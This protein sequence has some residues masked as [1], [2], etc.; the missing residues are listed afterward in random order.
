MNEILQA[1]QHELVPSIP[2]HQHDSWEL[3]YCTQGSAKFVFDDTELVYH[4]G[5]VVVIPPDTP[6]ILPIADASSCLLLSLANTA[7]TLRTPMLFHDD[8]N[9]SLLHL[10][11]DTAYLFHS[12]SEYRAVLL[13]AYGQLLAQHI[14]SRC[15]VS[16]RSQLVEEIAQSIVQNYTNP[17]YELDEL[18]RSAPYCYDYLCRLFRREL[19]TTPHKYL[20]DLRLQAAA[21]ILRTGNSGSVTEIARMCGYHD[22]LYF[23]RMFKKKYGVSPREY[24][25][26]AEA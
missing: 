6:H 26:T 25:K 12:A 15:T 17:N 2:R 22:P 8:G 7:L 10:F 21:D 9:R 18:L 16:P 4:V 20:T 24:A 23:S 13:P 14:S 3:F 5:D 19:H 11:Q 1:G